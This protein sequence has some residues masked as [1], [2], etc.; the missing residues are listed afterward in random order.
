MHA[1]LLQFPLYLKEV[2]EFAVVDHRV[3]VIGRAHWLRA[4]FG[5]IDYRQPA[6]AQA[7]W[8]FYPKTF[9]V[10][11]AVGDGACHRLQVVL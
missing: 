3:T 1:E 9:A 2:V 5:Q 6:M 10:W 4:C 8:S 11:T 7:D